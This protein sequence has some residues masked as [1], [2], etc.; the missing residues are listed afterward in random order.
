MQAITLELPEH[1]AEEVDRAVQAG[2]FVDRQEAIREALRE[3]LSARR[4]ELLESQQLDDIAWSLE[5]AVR[6]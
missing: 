4:L 2:W 1:L 5:T 6:T 3:Y